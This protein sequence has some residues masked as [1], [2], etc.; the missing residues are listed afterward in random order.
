MAVADLDGDGQPKVLVGGVNDA[1]EYKQ[2]TL[3]VFDHRSISGASSSPSGE[4]YFRGC[5]LGTEQAL[6][7]FGK[8][9]LGQRHEFNRV[10]DI[11]VEAGRIT[12][13][14]SESETY[15]DTNFVLY[16]LDFKLNILSATLSDQAKTRYREFEASGEFPKGS[17][18]TDGERLKRE[19]R[20]LRRQR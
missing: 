1:P 3:L 9:L 7:F 10:S 2:A 11:I 8:T 14:V 17:V 19:V 12:V 13:V 15:P 20:V 18:L 5:G 6:V 16:E 4:R